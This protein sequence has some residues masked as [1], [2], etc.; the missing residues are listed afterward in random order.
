VFFLFLLPAVFAFVM[1]IIIPFIMGIYYS[2]TDWSAVTGIDAEWV[3]LKNY[4]AIFK[5]ITFLHSFFVT[6]AYAVI[7][8]VVLNA[9]AFFMALLVTSNLKHTGIYRAGYFLP[10]LIGGLILGYIWQFIFNNAIPHLGG[11]IG[12]TWLKE[13]QFLAD[14]YLA[15]FAIV[16]VGTW[17]YAG[18]L[19]MIYVASIQSIPESLLEAAEIDGARFGQRLRHITFPLVAQAFTVSMFLTL[20]NSFKQ[21]DVNYA[22]TAGGPSGMFLDRA[23]MTNEFLALNIYQTAFSYRQ[24]AQGQSKAV[25][26]FI[27]LAIIS[28]IQVRVNKKRE[29]EL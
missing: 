14:R 27:V 28:L 16:I 7:S 17:Q 11:F 10:N 3:W 29:V 21:F 1:V 9:A 26:F 15:L 4:V 25:I 18:Y 23:I 8:I 19:M 2:F 12:F 13:H 6:A 22:L 24:L 20:V 5:D